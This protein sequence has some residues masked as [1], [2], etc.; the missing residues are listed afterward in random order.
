MWTLY[1]EKW[2]Y[3]NFWLGWQAKYNQWVPLQEN[4][5]NKINAR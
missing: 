1:K 3:V 2:K 4:N 5:N